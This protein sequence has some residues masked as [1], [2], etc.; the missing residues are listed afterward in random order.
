MRHQHPGL[1]ELSEQQERGWGSL[2]RDKTKTGMAEAPQSHWALWA[3]LRLS[4]AGGKL[5]LRSWLMVKVLSQV[6]PK[7]N[8]NPLKSSSPL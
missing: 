6:W 3:G 7:R 5:F 2:Q 1:W 4:H 8:V